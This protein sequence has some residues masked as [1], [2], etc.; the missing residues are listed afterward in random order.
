MSTP[1]Q[2]LPAPGAKDRHHLPRL[3]DERYDFAGKGGRRQR[4]EVPFVQRIDSITFHLRGTL[5]VD[6]IMNAATNPTMRGR[7]AHNILIFSGVE[8]NEFQQPKME[9]S[10]SLN[11]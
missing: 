3:S 5:K 6:H 8:R 10:M 9:V 2:I 7:P 11:T 4:N 1:R